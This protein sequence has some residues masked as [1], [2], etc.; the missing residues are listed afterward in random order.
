M[1]RQTLLA[2]AL[3]PFLFL[4]GCA[5]SPST[6]DAKM[7]DAQQL[8]AD[9]KWDEAFAAFSDVADDSGDGLAQFSLG[10]FYRLGW[11]RPVDD[12]KAA[13]WFEKAASNGIPAA[14]H[15]HAEFL[16]SKGAGS[17]NLK[18][19]AEWFE[20]AANNGHYGS[21]MAL[22]DLYLSGTGVPKSAEKAFRYAK[23]AAKHGV[24][25]AEIRVGR[26]LLKGEGTPADPAAAR[27]WLERAEQKGSAEAQYFLGLSCRDGLG[28]PASAEAAERW[29]EK[30][31]KQGYPSAYAPLGALYLGDPRANPEPEHL[32]S[33]YLWLSAA[34][35]VLKDPN[36]LAAAQKLL[37]RALAIM[38]SEWRAKLDQ[39]VKQHL[40]AHA[41]S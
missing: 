15:F 27:T 24:P 26:M 23:A 8:L 33:A 1:N 4:S 35:Q 25:G 36:E 21:W 5:D 11:G 19:A 31:A 41:G 34:T 30:A 3:F 39:Q 32:A 10:L 40:A 9:K 20:R 6:L 2:F 37:E 22:S 38:P 18:Q 29:F 12:A 17:P 14:Q 13:V 16:A 7:R 28:A